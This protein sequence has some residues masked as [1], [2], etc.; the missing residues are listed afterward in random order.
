MST[1]IA[2]CNDNILPDAYNCGILFLISSGILIFFLLIVSVVSILKLRFPIVYVLP[3]PLFTI[4][5]PVTVL[6]LSLKFFDV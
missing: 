2:S 3:S 4:D 5:I 6:S 1:V